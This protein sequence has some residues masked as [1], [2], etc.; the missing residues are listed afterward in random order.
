MKA[1]VILMKK[2]INNIAKFFIIIGKAL[3]KFI[4]KVLITPIS[5][6]VYFIIDKINSKPGRFEKF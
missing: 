1:K 3:Y 4:D 5:K 2:I 6:F